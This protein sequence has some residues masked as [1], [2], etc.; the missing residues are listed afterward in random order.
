MASLGYRTTLLT[1]LMDKAYLSIHIKVCITKK[2]AIMTFDGGILSVFYYFWRGSC[3]SSFYVSVL[4]VY[5]TVTRRVSL[6]EQELLALP[7]HTCSPPVVSGVHVVRSLVFCV[8]FCRSLF[9]FVGH[10]FVCPSTV[11]VGLWLHLW[12]LQNFLIFYV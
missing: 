7:E 2:S 1:Q 4:C 8:V 10:C 11:Y 5:F 9:F 12:H 6:V 3:C